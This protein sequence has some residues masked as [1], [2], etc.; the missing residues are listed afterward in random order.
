VQQEPPTEWRSWWSEQRESPK[1]LQTLNGAG[2]RIEGLEQG[3]WR[4]RHS[5]EGRYVRWK[6]ASHQSCSWLHLCVFSND[7]WL[8]IHHPFLRRRS[9]QHERSPSQSASGSYWS[10]RHCGGASLV[11]Q[12]PGPGPNGRHH[13]PILLIEPTIGSSSLTRSSTKCSGET[14]APGS[15]SSAMTPLLAGHGVGL[16][17]GS[18]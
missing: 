18:G 16:V 7:R 1:V 14:A 2:H 4:Q 9:G 11:V 15:G 12:S 8:G 13:P 6:A 5:A 3:R 17:A 10:C